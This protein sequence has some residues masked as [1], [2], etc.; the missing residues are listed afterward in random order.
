MAQFYRKEVRKSVPI[1]RRM[2]WKRGEDEEGSIILN[3]SYL[4]WD[5]KERRGG[6]K[7]EDLKG[8]RRRRR[9]KYEFGAV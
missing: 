4:D 5:S 1:R 6:D 8:R 7:E 9:E 2:E 3:S